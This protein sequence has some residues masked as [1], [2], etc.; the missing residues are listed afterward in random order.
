MNA[1]IKNAAARVERILDAA[2]TPVGSYYSDMIGGL[3]A[4]QAAL[5]TAIDEASGDDSDRTRD[6]VSDVAG[7]LNDV[8]VF[9]R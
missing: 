3:P 9:D 7:L 1:R 5:K 2:V 6:L 4:A 8:D